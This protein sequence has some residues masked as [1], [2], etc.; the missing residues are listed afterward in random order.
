MIS[1]M[2]NQSPAA[3]LS[4]QV[5]DF[6]NADPCGTRY[7]E[8]DDD[9]ERHAHERYGLEPHIARFAGF[10]R[11]QGARV[12]EIGVG[13]GSDYL[14]WM[15]AGAIATG[16]DFSATSIEKTRHRCQVAG[17]T[18]DL[19]VANAESL[20]FA[21]DSFDIVYSYGVMH[22]SADT[23]RCVGEAWRVLKPGGEARIMIYAHPSFT[24][25]MLWLRF[26]VLR[27]LSLRR[28]VYEYLE[29]PGTKTY[30]VAEARVLM[31][32]FQEVTVEQVLS[33]G[34]LL[35]NK[36]SQRFQ[37]RAYALIWKL[38]PRSLVRKLGRRWGLFLLISGKKPAI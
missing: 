28:S 31:E 26:G 5:R 3:A 17:Y 22:H 8:S 13:M 9:F 23:A 32:R 37:S 18:P 16:V 10:A 15:K 4:E 35:L 33:P 21:D 20:P 6:W 1:A 11:A 7:M 38:Y 19:Q 2:V 29:S 36:P 14:E 25:L 34:D 24:G 12:L 30:T 27:G